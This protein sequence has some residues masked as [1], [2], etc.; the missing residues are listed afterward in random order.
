[1][2]TVTNQMHHRK[3][4]HGEPVPVNRQNDK[5]HY[6]PANSLTCGKNESYLS[7]VGPGGSRKILITAR[8]VSISD[9]VTAPPTATSD[10]QI[11]STAPNILCDSEQNMKHQ[12]ICS[13]PNLLKVRVVHIKICVCRQNIP[14]HNIYFFLNSEMRQTKMYVVPISPKCSTGSWF[15]RT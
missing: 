13:V 5:Q 1:M 4:S 7:P 3:W 10:R 2:W 11:N 8:Y 12:C 9:V 14:Y 15:G 6:L